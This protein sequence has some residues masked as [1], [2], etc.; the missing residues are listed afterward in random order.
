MISTLTALGNLDVFATAMTLFLGW[1]WIGGLG[2]TLR[3]VV[4]GL[5]IVGGSTFAIKLLVATP[6]VTTWPDGVLVSQYFPS[7]HAAFAT[8]IYGS[9]A[10]VLAGASGGVWRYAP[11]GA[12]A[13]SV[14]V[15]AARVITR[16]H[17]I[18]DAFFGLVLGLSGPVTTYF[19]VLRE[20]HPY[21]RASL[22]LLGFIGAM[23]VGW[24]LPVP[25]HALS[26]W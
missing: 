3:G 5:L 20:R 17:P 11:L 4:L 1:L 21:P 23:I 12:L 19:A 26:P 9:V 7:G 6:G 13:L 22:I 8:A 15:A 25:I 16:T 24:F 18:G 2:R 10:I 14:A